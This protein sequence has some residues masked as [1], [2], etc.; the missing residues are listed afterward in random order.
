MTDLTDYTVYII[1]EV[2]KEMFQHRN[3]FVI[4]LEF[5]WSYSWQQGQADCMSIQFN[6]FTKKITKVFTNLCVLAT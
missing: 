2:N 3:A 4:E 6:L 5:N 1:L